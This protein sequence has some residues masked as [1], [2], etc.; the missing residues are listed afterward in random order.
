LEGTL[1]SWPMMF[2]NSSSSVA[3]RNGDC[4]RQHS[5]HRTT[6]IPDPQAS[7][8]RGRRGTTSRPQS[9]T[10]D[11]A[12]P[13]GPCS[14]AYHTQSASSCQPCPPCRCRSLSP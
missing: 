10:A 8:S 12:A 5:A 3:P 7:G 9:R 11:P 14:P 4:R 6:N 13:R 1:S 2:L